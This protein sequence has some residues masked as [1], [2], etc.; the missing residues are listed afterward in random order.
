VFAGPGTVPTLPPPPPGREGWPW[1]DSEEVPAFPDRAGGWPRITIVTP[2]FNQGRYLEETIRSV[3]LQGY[4]ELEYIVIDGGS[5]DSS[6]EILRRYEG[7]LAHWVSERDSGQTVA[8]NKGFARAGGKIHGYLNSDDAYRPN[9]FARVAA[10]FLHDPN[11]LHAFPVVDIDHRG[12]SR[13]RSVPLRRRR[14]LALATYPDRPHPPAEG[15]AWQG[16]LVPLM[17]GE[18]YLHQPGVFWPAESYFEQGGFD[19]RYSFMFDQKFFLELVLAGLPLICHGGSPVASFRHHELSKTIIS[20]REGTNPFS[21]E[22]WRIAREL[23]PRLNRSERDLVRRRRAQRTLG[24]VWR[25]LRSGSSRGRAMRVLARGIAD[26]PDLL[27][28][29]FFWTTLL[30]VGGIGRVER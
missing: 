8:I 28:D 15:E 19:E 21:L 7:W 3:L 23:E 12:A 11:A 25:E 26:H 1:T 2:S 17:V 22:L 18:L 27:A 14:P 16:S 5:T 20:R 30:A 10:A 29:R 13:L 4:P 24:R 9:A 6:V